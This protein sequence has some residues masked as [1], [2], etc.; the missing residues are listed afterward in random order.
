MGCLLPHPNSYNERETDIRVL[1]VSPETVAEF[2]KQNVGLNYTDQI[3]GA[4]NQRIDEV[5][6][7]GGHLMHIEYNM[8]QA[9]L[10]F[11]ALTVAVRQ[12]KPDETEG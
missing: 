3:E 1:L 2:A 9:A 5:K 12:A 11:A 7:V 10:F 4:I 6:T 8:S